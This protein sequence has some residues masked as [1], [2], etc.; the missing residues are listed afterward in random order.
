MCV[1]ISWMSLTMKEVNVLTPGSIFGKDFWVSRFNSLQL[2]WLERICGLWKEVAG[3]GRPIMLI[4]GSEAHPLSFKGEDLVLTVRLLPLSIEIK[5]FANK[6][7]GQVIPPTTF[8][9]MFN[10]VYTLV[11]FKSD[12]ERNCKNDCHC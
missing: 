4:D 10:C 11:H 3:S 7:S 5:R 8:K 9:T 6:A 2:A 12:S 1:N